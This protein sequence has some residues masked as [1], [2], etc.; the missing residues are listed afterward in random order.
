VRSDMEVWT[1][2]RR[3]VL[4]GQLSQRAACREYSLGWWTLKK[5]LTHDQPPGYRRKEPKAKPKLSAFLPI[6]AQILQDDKS[7]PKNQR[8]TAKRIWE[9]LRDEHGF[10][11]CYTIVKDVVREWKQSHREVFL[12]LTHP[13]GEAQVDF[14]EATV[15]LAGELTKVALFVMTLPYSGAIFIQVF[16]RE[17]TETFLEGHRLAFEYLG[18]VPRRI[19][20]DNLAIAVIEV[21][22]GR[23]R[24]LTR[25][26][27]RLQ[28][29]YLFQEHFCLVRRANEKG[30]V[31]RL[32]GCAR[33]SFLVP[34][35]EV[36]TLSA[37]NIALAARCREDLTHRTRG[38]H[39]TKEELL[40][41]DRAAFLS[42]PEQPFEARR[43]GQA[44]ADSESLVRFD[45]NSY[46]VPVKYAHRQITVVATVDEVKLVY[47]DRLVARHR[48]SWRKE[49]YLYNPIHYLAL[50]ERKPGGFDHA[51][52]LERWELPATFA[53]LR[54]RLEAADSR[55][56]TRQ[57]IRVLQLLERYSLPQL[58][59]AVEYALDID[60]LDPDS[61]RVIV[62]HRGERPAEFFSLDGRPHLRAI[63]IETTDVAAY[64]ALL[65]EVTS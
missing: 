61:I 4:T 65:G 64:Q 27:L 16:P 29:H 35:P 38:K 31:E 54:R 30:H 34:V 2:V 5:I 56:G 63:R 37:L 24:K 47:E 28:S 25:E 1:E 15:K 6:I 3:R 46:S 53:L 12:P 60:V 41:E 42:L 20:Y 33:K 48:R 23:E 62:E 59:D 32:L 52:P 9:R 49:Q 57:F 8:H 39:G 45:T 40:L 26:F 36:D 50:L 22:A 7:V 55:N 17:C 44:A 13:P 19:S 14:G 58:S 11:G 21:L 43:I 18:G 51:K 10:A